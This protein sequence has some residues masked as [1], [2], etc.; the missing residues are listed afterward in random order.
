M[1]SQPNTVDPNIASISHYLRWDPAVEPQAPAGY[2]GDLITPHAIIGSPIG[3]NHFRIT[4]PAFDDVGGL[5]TD[6]FIISG[7]LGTP[8]II[9]SVGFGEL[10][11]TGVP[12]LAATGDM[13]TGAPF[14]LDLR[15]AAPNT[16]S[17]LF[18]S[19]SQANL[20]FQGGT[21]VPNPAQGFRLPGVTDGNGDLT[22]TGNFPGAPPGTRLYLQWFVNDLTATGGSAGSNSLQIAVP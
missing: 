14:S 15:S 1:G 22:M 6:Q 12:N 4:G 19:F 20:P 13:T 3:Q 8:D 7:K 9:Q 11:T 10:G 5:E 2:L 18:V 16:M 21:L 17:T